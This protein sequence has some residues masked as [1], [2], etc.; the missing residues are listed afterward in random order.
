M[1]WVGHEAGRSIRS[2]LGLNQAQLVNLKRWRTALSAAEY[3][4]CRHSGDIG[5][6]LAGKIPVRDKNL[7]LVPAAGWTDAYE[8]SGYIPHAELPRLV[9][10]PSGMI[11]TANNR[12]VGD[13]YPYF[14]GAEFYPGFRA[15]RIEEML[16]ERER[17]TI[18]EMEEIQLDNGSKYAEALTPWIKLLQ[19]EDPWEKV[20]LQELRRWKC[21]MDG[22][23]IAAMIFQATR[24]ELLEMIFGDKL[25]TVKDSYLGISKTPLFLITALQP[26]EVHMLDLIS[27]HESSP[28]YADVATGRKRTRDQLLQEAFS[29]AVK[30]VRS[31]VSEVTT[32]WQ[33]ARQHQVRYVH[34]LGSARFVGRFFDRGPLTVGGDAY[35]PNVTR[36]APSKPPG[37]VQVIA[38]YRQIYEVGAWDRAESV[39]PLGQS[40]HPL[41]DHYDN[42][43]MM[44]KE[45]PII[46]CPGQRR[47]GR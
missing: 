12:M 33:W 23:S 43:M 19:S 9:N 41:S 47:G 42:Q 10:P 24:L 2:L 5:Y 15:A 44:W 27:N 40:G 13:D 16:S 8:W 17:F 38:S 20:A 28:W 26:A 3:H 11:V 22:D 31:D 39:L 30:W 25:G 18:R 4:L 21:S 29:R 14:L 7:G 36:A 45:A 35:S 6:L 37:L 1:R 32:R 46:V 34:P